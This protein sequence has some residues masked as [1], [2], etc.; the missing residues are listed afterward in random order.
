VPGVPALLLVGVSGVAGSSSPR[1]E[2][3]CREGD[4]PSL[5]IIVMSGTAEKVLKHD[6]LGLGL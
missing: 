4:K 3:D 2:G 6:S 5:A 1:F